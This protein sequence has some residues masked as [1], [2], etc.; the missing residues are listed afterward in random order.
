MKQ[1]RRSQ[2]KILFNP[3]IWKTDDHYLMPV[4][5][6]MLKLNAY[7]CYQDSLM[8][9]QMRHHSNTNNIDVTQNL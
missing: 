1:N 2:I 3:E 6:L 4:N 5:P 8:L 9:D 7:E